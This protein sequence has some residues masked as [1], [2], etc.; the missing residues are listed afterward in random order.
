MAYAPKSFQLAR[1]TGYAAMFGGIAVLIALQ[2]LHYI[3]RTLTMC[4]VCVLTLAASALLMHAQRYRDEIQRQVA[5]KRFYWGF[6]I[7]LLASLPVLIALM[8]PNTTWLDNLVQFAS[9][10]HAMPRIYFWAG[11]MLPVL[12]Q[13]LGV[14][15]LRLLAK[16]RSGA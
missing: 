3:D 14:L 16:L 15:S 8:L 10:H 2:K 1:R 9:R 5:E 7:G 12:F 4:L 6:Q 11:F 13:V